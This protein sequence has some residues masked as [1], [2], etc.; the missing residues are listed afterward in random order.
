MHKKYAKDGLVAV[1]VSVDP[2]EP[3][4]EQRVLKFLRDKQA[5]FTNLLLDE[6]AELWQEK[7]HT[8]A[9]PCI[10][11]FNRELKWTQYTGEIKHDEIEKQVVELLKT[12]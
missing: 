5:T 2:I 9:V 12:K 10:Y 1:S 7:L 8:D 11:V 6:P 4:I 3:G